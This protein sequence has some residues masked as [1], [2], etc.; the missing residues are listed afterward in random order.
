MRKLFTLLVALLATTTLWAYDFQSGDLYYNITSDIEPYTV[1]VTYKSLKIYQ[2]NKDFSLTTV[3]IPSTVTYNG[4]VYSVTRIGN[5][6]FDDCSSIQTVSIPKSV[7]SIGNHAF[8]W[9]TSLSSVEIPNGVTKIA[10]DTFNSCKVLSSVIIPESV[11][12]IG[13]AA[14]YNCNSLSTI[15]IPENV[16]TIGENSFEKCIFAKD[17]FINNSSL[18]EEEYNY[19]GAQFVEQEIDGLLINN[20]TVV[21]C[22]NNVVHANIPGHV[23]SIGNS[24]FAQCKSL[25]SVVINN[26]VSF[27]DWNAFSYCESLKNITIPNSVIAIRGECFKSCSALESISIPNSVTTIGGG[28]FYRCSSLKSIVLSE[29]IKSL[30]YY[31]HGFFEDCTSLTDCIIPEGIETIEDNA[32]RGCTAL[33][34]VSIPNSVKCIEKN[35]FQK[36]ALY[37]DSSNWENDMLYVDDCL[38]E[39]KASCTNY[40]IKETTRLIADYAFS[41]CATLVSL[42]IPKSVRNVTRH[43][44]SGQCSPSYIF[45]QEGNEMYD[46]RNNCN[47]I[48]ETATNS[49]IYGCPNTTIPNSITRINDYAFSGYSSIQSIHIP[50]NVLSIG[51]FAFYNCKSLVSVSM[52]EGIQCIGNQVFAYCDSLSSISIANSVIKIGIGSLNFTSIYN[53]Y[54]KWE[55]DVLYIDDCCISAKYSLLGDYIVKSGTRLIAD[56]AFQYCDSVN[57]IDI[58]ETVKIIGANAF[59]GCSSLTSINIPNGVTYIDKATFSGCSALLSIII[60]ENVN[61]IG[62]YAFYRCASIPSITLPNSIMSIG[63]NAFLDCKSLT[64]VTIGNGVTSIGDKAFT[65]CDRLSDIYCYAELPPS[66]QESS[67]PHYYAYV[68]VPCESIQHYRSDNVW[69]KFQNL[70]CL[71]IE[72]TD[73]ENVKGSSQTLNNCNKLLHDGQILILRDGKTYNVMGQEL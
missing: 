21:K 53:D 68:Y 38:I 55:N 4:Q 56:G 40:T 65:H 59:D 11:T 12:T 71:D 8:Y 64:S 50:S 20:D 72:E 62:D 6:A 15:Y 54:S 41:K 2:Y 44:F 66:S 39:V 47:A 52:D 19:W 58:P 17:K 23:V 67:F 1:E 22:R 61:S 73:I 10:D 24:A 14:F 25:E 49:L 18:D 35:V 69:G 9:C 5:H 45:V 32:F 60:P 46:S 31:M 48:I 26:G 33:K 29:N 70:Q 51:N 3:D 42:V 16:E 43:A 27:I 28:V 13:V 37:M 34:F 30:P 57:T 63:N 7:I 36:T